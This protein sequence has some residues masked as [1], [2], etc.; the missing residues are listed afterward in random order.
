[1]TTQNVLT[2]SIG[3]HASTRPGRARR[4]IAVTALVTA[5]SGCHS[6]PPASP[7]QMAHCSHV[8]SLW[9]RYLQDAMDQSGER[10]RAEKMLFDCQ[11][12]QYETQALE[13]IVKGRG[14]SD[15]LIAGDAP[16]LPP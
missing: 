15:E 9:L 10:A 13:T 8:Y 4:L 1:M 5:I 11:N 12:A 3:N 6:A 2:T 7:T 14:F 16:I